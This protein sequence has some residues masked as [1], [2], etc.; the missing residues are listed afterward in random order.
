MTTASTRRS[1]VLTVSLCALLAAGCKT[2]E[3]IPDDAASRE[4]LALVL[5]ARI[6]IVEPFTRPVSMGRTGDVDGIEVLIQAVNALEKPGVM[7]VGSLRVE[8]YE[9]VPASGEPRGRQLN[10]WNIDL[11][12]RERQADHWNPAT[13]MYEFRLGLDRAAM[14][15]SGSYVLLATYRSPLGEYLTDEMVV[16]YQPTRQS[17]SSRP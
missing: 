7:I 4:M 5:P 2:A 12:T 3:S 1:I 16:R 13:Q 9:H 8:L 6:E 11:S 10:R 17:D 14:S 15:A